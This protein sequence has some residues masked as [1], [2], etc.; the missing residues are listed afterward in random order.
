MNN[1]KFKRIL[2]GALA[3]L[4]LLSGQAQ[5]TVKTRLD[6]AD[7]LIGE[8]VQLQ[9]KCTANANQHVVFPDFKPKTQLVPGVEVVSN[10]QIDTVKINQGR[11]LELTRRYTVTSFD[12]ALYALPP[13]KVSVDGKEYSSTNNVGLK[14]STVAVDTI[15]VDQFNPPHGVINMPFKWSWRFVS[16]AVFIWALALIVLALVIRYS[17]PRL[18][19]RRVFI[20]PPVPPHVT[21][22]KE[23]EHIKSAP[24][25]DSKHYYMQLTGTLRDYIE[26]RFGFNAREMTTTEIIDQLCTIENAESLDELKNVLLTADLVKF[27]QYSASMS[28][29]DRNLIQALQF[30]DTTKIEPKEQP[31][32]R[33]EYVTLSGGNQHKLRVAMFSGIIIL[34]LVT[35]GLLIYTGYNLY[36]CFA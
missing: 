6:T 18:I 34:T 17:D 26:K 15:H 25:E 21:A 36:G 23:I 14:V 5:V 20:H 30:V 19:T 28:E 27:A 3:C 29:Q 35:V 31:K 1:S 33:V 32:P 4:S 7:I 11:Q 13:M 10:D 2:L 8:Q 9:V 12:S 16:L 22:I 24:K